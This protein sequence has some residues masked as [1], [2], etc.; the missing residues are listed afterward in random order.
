MKLISLALPLLLA[1]PYHVQATNCVPAPSGLVGWWRAETN[2]NDSA[3]TNNGVLINGAGLGP[4][5]VGQAFS[6]TSSDQGVLI[7]DAP[8]LDPTNSLSVEAWVLLSNYP[9]TEGVLVVYKN[10]YFVQ[11]GQYAIAVYQTGSN[12]IFQAGLGVVPTGDLAMFGTTSLQLNTWYHVAITYNAAQFRLY[13]NGQLENTLAVTGPVATTTGPLKIGGYGISPYA[14]PGRVDEVSLYNR[15]LSGS[16]VQAL[17]SAGSAGKCLPVAPFILSQ[18]Q[19]QVGYWGGRVTFTVTA[20]GTPPPGYLWYKDGFS[21]SWATNSSLVLTNLSLNEGGNYWVVV[22]NALGSVTSSNAFLTVNPAGV[23][24]GLYAGLTIE[25]SV[26]NTYGIQYTTNVSQA[27]TW[28]TLGQ[29]TLTQPLQLW[30]D[31]NANVAA[32]YSPRRFYRVVAIP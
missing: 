32:G 12:S 16:E 10:I 29:I 17:Y 19:G 22:S 20:G 13:V 18:P 26:G 24:L 14:L 11:P 27:A 2:S 21:I 25:G 3:G 5:E 8:E 28:S 15:A 31:T 30:T 9:N 4:G 23:S 6:F 7:A 1:L